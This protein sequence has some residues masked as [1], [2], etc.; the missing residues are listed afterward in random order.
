[1]IENKVTIVCVSKLFDLKQEQ[2]SHMLVIT[3]Y[4]I[5]LEKVTHN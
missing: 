4:I 1:M 3:F 5:V 2:H